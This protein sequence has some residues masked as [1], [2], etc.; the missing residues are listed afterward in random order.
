VGND[1]PRGHLLSRLS[2]LLA[3][4]RRRS[5]CRGAALPNLL[6][7]A[8]ESRPVKFGLSAAV[9][10]NNGL[11]NASRNLSRTSVIRSR[12]GFPGD[13][14]GSSRR[15]DDA[16]LR[17]PAAEAPPRSRRPRFSA[18]INAPD[19]SSPALHCPDYTLALR[20]TRAT[21]LLTLS[22]FIVFQTVATLPPPRPAPPSFAHLADVT[23][24]HECRT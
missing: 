13:F 19:L 1:R 21:S 2:W 23:T 9:R 17:R 10:D 16:S 8:E 12:G 4:K 20:P 3:P 15:E 7:G 6:R 24:R 5:G 22:P 18:D 11:T 14:P